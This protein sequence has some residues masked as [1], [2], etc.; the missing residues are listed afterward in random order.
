MD[1]LGY[2]ICTAAIVAFVLITWVAIG[3]R[4]LI[5]IA[6]TPRTPNWFLTLPVTW[7][8]NQLNRRKL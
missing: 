1:L 7:I 4:H 5:T 3:V 6:F 8:L 2:L